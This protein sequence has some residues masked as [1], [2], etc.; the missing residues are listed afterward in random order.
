[1]SAPTDVTPLSVQSIERMVLERM[2][3]ELAAAGWTDAAGNP[4]SGAWLRALFGDYTERLMRAS[5][6]K[7]VI[8]SGHAR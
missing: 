2:A 4:P 8:A 5:G 3:S 1:M 6:G 7:A